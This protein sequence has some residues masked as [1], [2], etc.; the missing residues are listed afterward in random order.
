MSLN[1]K[2]PRV[3][4]MAREAA[5]RTG[6][7]QTSVIELALQRFLASLSSADEELDALIHALQAR[8]AVGGPLSTDD[9]YDEDGLPR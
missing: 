5:A 6:M 3:H 1:V 2:N 9:L 4:E 7:S 8:I